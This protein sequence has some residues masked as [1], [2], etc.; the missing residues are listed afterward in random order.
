MPTIEPFQPRLLGEKSWGTELLIAHTPHYT[1]KVLTMRAGASGPLQYHEQK[2]E[3]FYLVSGLARVTF[4]PDPSVASTSV[5]EM[6]PGMS[7]HVPPGAIHKVTA[8]TECVFFEAST[9]HFD[10]R[11]AV[12]HH[13]SHIVPDVP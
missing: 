9:P 4:E 11:V 10:D 7:I 6:M 5:M 3:T 2:D 12:D 8:V 1:G 13:D